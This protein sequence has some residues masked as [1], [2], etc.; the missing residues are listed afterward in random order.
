MLIDSHCHL[1][2][3]SDA[4]LPDVLERA[5]SAGVTRF[6][7]I[8]VRLDQARAVKAMAERHADVWG[9]VGVHPQNV[10]EGPLPAVEELVAASNHPRI[11]GLGESGLDYFYDKAPAEVQ[12]EGFRRHIAAARVTGLPL[13]IHARDADDD[14]ARILREEMEAGAFPFLLHCFSSGVALAQTALELGGYISFS[15]M[16]TFPKAEALRT[17]AATVPADRLLVET[18]APYLAPTP[19]RGKRNEPAFVKLTAA[20]LAELRAVTLEELATQT[21]RNFVTLFRQAQ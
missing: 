19:H 3:F 4:E 11:I 8:G 9:T 2:Y 17:I 12:Q 20:R 7:T 18:D 14:I 1:D 6:V 13:V 5:R 21:S 15:G 10:G 16:V